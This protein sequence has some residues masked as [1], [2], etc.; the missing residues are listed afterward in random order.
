MRILLIIFSILLTSGC[1]FKIV[2]QSS[3][4]NYNIAI[5]KNPNYTWAYNNRG[6]LKKDM[7]NLPGALQDFNKAISLE[8]LDEC[9]YNR[10]NTYLAM[11]KKI[12]SM[13]DYNKCL[14]INPKHPI[15][16]KMKEN[17]LQIV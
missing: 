10:G 14:E 8:S 9:Y 13:Q 2:N 1:G 17:V 11:G 4:D 5:Q 3:L 15:I 7:G 12:E 16:N 6:N